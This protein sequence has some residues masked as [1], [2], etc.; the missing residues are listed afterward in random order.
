M[1]TLF[2]VFKKE[3]QCGALSLWMQNMKRKYLISYDWAVG[4]LET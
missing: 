1:K 3:F 2:I 4:A